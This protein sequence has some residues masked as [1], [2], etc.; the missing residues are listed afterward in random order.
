MAS[1]A[2]SILLTGQVAPQGEPAQSRG[3]RAPILAGVHV[4]ESPPRY[5]N[6]MRKQRESRRE[7]L[8][9]LAVLQI[10]VKRG[11]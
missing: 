7:E 8:T 10:E 5:T 6:T 1:G 9:E 2:S 3:M 11:K 4:R